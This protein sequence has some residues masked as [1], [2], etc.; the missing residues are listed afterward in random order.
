MKLGVDTG[1]GSAAPA[2]LLPSGVDTSPG[3]PPILS[4]LPSLPIS[5]ASS[6]WTVC[7]FLPAQGQSALAQKA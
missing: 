7:F 4:D 3:L 1:P 6:S 2:D 5:G